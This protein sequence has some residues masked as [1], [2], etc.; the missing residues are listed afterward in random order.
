M[1]IS[2]TDNGE[3]LMRRSFGAAEVKETIGDLVLVHGVY[4]THEDAAK[5]IT[6][7]PAK[8]ERKDH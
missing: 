2:G 4:M 1:T 6:D 8:I 3:F 5:V 7:T